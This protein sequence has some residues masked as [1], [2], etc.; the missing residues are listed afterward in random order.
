MKNNTI[1]SAQAQLN[2]V[3][4]EF[5]RNDKLGRLCFS[6]AAGAIELEKEPRWGGH[7]SAIGFAIDEGDDNDEE[8]EDDDEDDWE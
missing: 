5:I 4:D 3:I 8:E 7:V 6:N 2:K 1:Y